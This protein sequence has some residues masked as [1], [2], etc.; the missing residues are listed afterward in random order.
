M[1][2]TD[3]L[4]IFLFVFLASCAPSREKVEAIVYELAE[5]A[6][7]FINSKKITS[8]VVTKKEKPKTTIG[9]IHIHTILQS[10]IL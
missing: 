3:I 4:I 7:T 5:K 9:V 8:L 10:N 1:K 2:A 6:L